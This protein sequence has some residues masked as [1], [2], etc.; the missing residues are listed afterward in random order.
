MFLLGTTINDHFSSGSESLVHDPLHVPEISLGSH[1]T[2]QNTECCYNGPVLVMSA[3]EATARESVC[4][5]NGSGI[6]GR[7]IHVLALCLISCP[8]FVQYSCRGPKSKLF[9]TIM[10]VMSLLL[11]I[12]CI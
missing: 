1:R 10:F 8:H 11:I 3:V 9:K 12:K 4:L 7:I 6:V 5:R 2:E